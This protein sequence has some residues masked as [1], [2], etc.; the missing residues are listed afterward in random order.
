MKKT[1][2]ETNTGTYFLLGC[3][4]ENIMYWLKSPSWDC[5]WYWGFGYIRSENGHQHAN[6][7]YGKWWGEKDSILIETTFTKSEGVG[8]G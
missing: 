8:V 3:D 5:G 4:S 2:R 6:N 7:F 1:I